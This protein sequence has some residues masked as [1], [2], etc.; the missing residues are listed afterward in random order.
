M[1]P[2]RENPIAGD[3]VQKRNCNKTLSSARVVIEHTF[4]LLKGRFRRLK[5][6]ETS[7]CAGHRRVR[8]MHPAQLVQVL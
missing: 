6:P 3:D 4:G 7:Q 1:T 2:F 8:C 5:Y